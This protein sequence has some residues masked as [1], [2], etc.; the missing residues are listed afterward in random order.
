MKTAEVG[1]IF[2]FGTEKGEQMH[3]MYKD[4]DGTDKPIYLASYGVGITRVMGVLVEKFADEKGIV[5]PE[6]VS[7]YNVHLVLLNQ[8]DAE[9]R[10]WADGIYASL[11]KGGADVLYDDRD[12]TTGHKFADSDLI[13]IPQRI[14]VSKKAREEGRFE[15]I[16]RSTGETVRMT[17]EELYQNFCTKDVE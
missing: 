3:V 13:G 2:K 9:I 16:A 12:A 8:Q 10:D 17:E 1:N 11:M 6:S 4:S 14:I 5:W 7:P 15:V